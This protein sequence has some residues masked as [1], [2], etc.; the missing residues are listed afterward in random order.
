M[1][2]PNPGSREQHNHV[3]AVV[4]LHLLQSGSGLLFCGNHKVV[5]DDIHAHLRQGCFGPLHNGIIDERNAHGI[6]E[7][8]FVNAVHNETDCRLDQSPSS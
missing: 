1:C 2:C 8:V 3:N 4:A 5:L 6:F 7:P